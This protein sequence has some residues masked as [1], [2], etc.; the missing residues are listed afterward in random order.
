MRISYWS[1]DVCSSDLG[2]LQNNAMQAA[3]LVTLGFSRSQELEADQLGV[4]Y[5]KRAGYDPMAL[6]TVLARLANQTNLEARVA[7][8]AA[9]ALPEWASTHPDP[10]SRAPHSQTLAS[11]TGRAGRRNA[12]APM[13]AVAGVPTRTH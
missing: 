3:Q 11:R 7:G 4:Q 1:S 2:F 8:G 13:P 5:L 10:A 12:A 6:S 9:R